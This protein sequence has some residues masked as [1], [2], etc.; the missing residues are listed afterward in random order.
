MGFIRNHDP[1]RVDTLEPPNKPTESYILPL[2]LVCIRW[3]PQPTYAAGKQG[4]MGGCING[5]EASKLPNSKNCS[6]AAYLRC[7]WNAAAHTCTP[8]QHPFRVCATQVPIETKVYIYYNSFF[9]NI[10]RAIMFVTVCNISA[11]FYMKRD[12]VDWLCVVCV[13]VVISDGNGRC[14]PDTASI[15]AVRRT[16]RLWCAVVSMHKC[17]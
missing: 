2:P 16:D 9:F 4:V 6:S 5:L 15:A 10:R 17:N 14:M 13:R 12:K 7:E 3:A 11:R 8:T 1:K